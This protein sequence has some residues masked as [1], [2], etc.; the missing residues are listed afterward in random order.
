MRFKLCLAL[1]FPMVLS[2]PFDDSNMDSCSSSA[3]NRPVDDANKDILEKIDVPNISSTS[4]TSCGCSGSQGLNRNTAF[5]KIT[6]SNFT[7]GSTLIARSDLQ[8]V[9]STN[10]GSNNNIKDMVFISGGLFYMG[11]KKAIIPTDGETPKRLVRVSSFHIDKYEVSNEKYREFVQHTNYKTESEL[12]GW[13]FVFEHAN[14]PKQIKESI[15]QAVAGAEW[16]LPVPG[17]YWLEPEGP[18]TNVFLTNRSN[19]PVVQVSWN[20]AV[21]YCKWRGG[22]LPTEAE[23]EYAAQGPADSSNTENEVI[24]IKPD[25]FPWGKSLLTNKTRHRA[26]IY[27]GVFPHKSSTEDGYEFLSPVDAY[28]PQ[29]GYGLFNMIGN[30]WEWVEDWFTTD[31]FS[32][33]VDV[34]EENSS[35]ISHDNR[36]IRKRIAHEP[37][38]I[39]VNPVGPATGRDKVKKGGSFLCHKS[40]CYRYRTA[41]RYFTTPDSASINTGFRCAMDVEM[42]RNFDQNPNSNVHI[43]HNS[44]VP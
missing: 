26:N 24:K 33:L 39:F 42:H 15:T 23:W 32:Y 18:N 22:R 37:D 1:Y 35:N 17:S 29:N 44:P 40:Y 28:E 31:H 2:M 38:T 41:A 3:S 8:E 21:A 4:S 6:N 5:E 11:L 20:D 19:Y 30:A 25:M 16:W 13:S 34:I 43:D 14:I 7:S 9:P 27:Q 36:L 10:I 12:F